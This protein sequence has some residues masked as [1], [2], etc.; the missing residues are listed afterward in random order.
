ML[1]K[2]GSGDPFHEYSSSYIPKPM[3][4]RSLYPDRQLMCLA[5]DTLAQS[6]ELVETTRLQPTNV[7]SSGQCIQHCSMFPNVLWAVIDG[8]NQCVCGSDLKFD[9]ALAGEGGRQ[10]IYNCPWSKSHQLGG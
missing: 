5:A 6:V 8:T 7:I 3:C 4:E 1:L 9:P 10:P 2:T